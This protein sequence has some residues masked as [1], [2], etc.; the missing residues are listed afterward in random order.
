[1]R[2]GILAEP[3]RISSCFK[4]T[5][6]Q[7][8]N[9]SIRGHD[10]QIIIQQRSLDRVLEAFAGLDL[11]RVSIRKLRSVPLLSRASQAIWNTYLSANPGNPDSWLGE[12]ID[13]G[14]LVAHG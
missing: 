2:V 13:F 3:P 12:G 14:T 10:V 6:E 5:T 8:R 1:M 4:I 7:A 9:L 11:H